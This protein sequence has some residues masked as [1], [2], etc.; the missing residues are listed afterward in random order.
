M[1]ENEDNQENEDN[2]ENEN[3]KKKR[4]VTRRRKIKVKKKKEKGTYLNIRGKVLKVKKK[5]IYSNM[6]KMTTILITKV[7]VK[8]MTLVMTRSSVN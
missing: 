7:M 1:E 6:E 8:T 4:K 5:K 3:E 2:R